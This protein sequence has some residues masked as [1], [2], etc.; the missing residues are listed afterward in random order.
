MC[1][2]SETVPNQNEKL[3]FCSMCIGNSCRGRLRRGVLC[4][5]LD[6]SSLSTVPYAKYLNGRFIHRGL[7]LD[8][9]RTLR[10]FLERRRPDH[11]LKNNK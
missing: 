8:R 5:V 7:T 10:Q 9:G 11:N 3:Y 2:E 1:F 4:K 6:L